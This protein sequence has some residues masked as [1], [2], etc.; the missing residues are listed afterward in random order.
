MPAKTQDIRK[1]LTITDDL[2][3]AAMVVARRARQ[4]NEEYFQKKRDNQ[5]M[6]ELDGG[7][8]EDVLAM[9][10]EEEE[11]PESEMEENPINVALRDFYN[12]KLHYY[13]DTPKK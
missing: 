8:E 12:R 3:E 6:E 10:Q 4:I 2:Y 1:I 11:L 5:I 9:E 7:Y 13:Y